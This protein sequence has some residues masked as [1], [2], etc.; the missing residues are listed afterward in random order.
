MHHKMTRC[1]RGKDRM[2]NKRRREIT[3]IINDKRKRKEGEEGRK[4]K[5]KWSRVQ[6]RE[7]KKKKK[8]VNKY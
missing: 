2:E 1:G 5:Q 8:S 4:I 3:T 7:I 6:R